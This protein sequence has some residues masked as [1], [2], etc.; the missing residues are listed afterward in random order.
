[1]IKHY[2]YVSAILKL[3]TETQNQRSTV[4]TLNAVSL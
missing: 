2:F 1:M 4:W 3:P